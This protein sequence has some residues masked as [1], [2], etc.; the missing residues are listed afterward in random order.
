MVVRRYPTRGTVEQKM[1]GTV[2]RVPLCSTVSRCDNNMTSAALNS[3]C[4]PQCA[5]YIS[6][7]PY[8]HI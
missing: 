2:E 5:M 7:M 1:R 4:I 6:R 8:L 3:V